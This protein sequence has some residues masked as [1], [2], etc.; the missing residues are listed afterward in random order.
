MHAH[1]HT[2][3]HTHTHRAIDTNLDSLI[4]HSVV[5]DVHVLVV[6]VRHDF[7]HGVGPAGDGLDGVDL[8][9]QRSR[10]EG[11]GANASADIHQRDVLVR[12]QA[13]VRESTRAN[14]S[15]RAAEVMRLG[16]QVCL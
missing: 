16:R 4:R 13:P 6:K 12:E 1:T 5:D 11:H 9:A 8:S 3:A 7:A 2:R 15:Q 14:R 10:R